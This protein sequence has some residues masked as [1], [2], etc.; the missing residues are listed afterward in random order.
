M[1]EPVPIN[2]AAV[3]ESGENNHLMTKKVA[4]PI[5]VARSTAPRSA[6]YALEN[7]SKERC[8]HGDWVGS[9]RTTGLQ[10]NC[11]FALKVFREGARFINRLDPNVLKKMS[12]YYGG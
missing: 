10:C 5:A 9:V 1:H 11:Y 12:D 7:A 6:A 2:L 8:T 3:A 4:S